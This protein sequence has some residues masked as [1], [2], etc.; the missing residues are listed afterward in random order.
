MAQPIRNLIRHAVLASVLLAPGVHAEGNGGDD[1]L[2]NQLRQTTLEL[3]SAQEQLASLRAENEALKAAAAAPKPVVEAVVDT[4]AQ[5][6]LQAKSAQLE[7]AKAEAEAQRQALAKWQT[8]YQEAAEVARKRDAELRQLNELNQR[9]TGSSR[10]C[11]AKNQALIEISQQLLDRYRRKGLF[12]S[13]V[14]A[15]PLTGIARV[16]F[17]NLLQDYDNRIADQQANPA[18]VSAEGTVPE[19]GAAEAAPAAAPAPEAAAPAAATTR[20]P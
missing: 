7:T 2:R 13:L 4:R 20:S 1:R 10:D 6:A 17:E 5:R 14:E 9:T 16:R 19:A 18:A 11:V 8:A 12:S 3:R 15:E